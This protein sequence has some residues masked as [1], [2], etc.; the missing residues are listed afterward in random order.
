MLDSLKLYIS[1]DS[2]VKDLSTF[3]NLIIAENVRRVEDKYGI[4]TAAVEFY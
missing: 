4:P 2:G 1:F 3:N